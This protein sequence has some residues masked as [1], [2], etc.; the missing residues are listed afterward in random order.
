MVLLITKKCI[1]CYL[2]EPECP[3]EAI[4]FTGEYYKINPKLCTECLG[5]YKQPA[6]KQVCPIKGAIINKLNI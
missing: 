1:S 3:N 5:Y 4:S 2:C 6:C